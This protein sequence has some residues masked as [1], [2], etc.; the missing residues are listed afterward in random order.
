[1][2]ALAQV[3]ASLSLSIHGTLS[4]LCASLQVFMLY[5]T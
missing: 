2:A 1:M 3:S 5:E 4:F